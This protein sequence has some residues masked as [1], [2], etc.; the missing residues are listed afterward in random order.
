MQGKGEKKS[1]PNRFSLEKLRGRKKNQN[2]M[3]KNTLK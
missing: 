2:E 3:T 1:N